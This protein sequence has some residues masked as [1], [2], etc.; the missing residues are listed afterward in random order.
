MAKRG[1]GGVSSLYVTPVGSGWTPLGRALLLTHNIYLWWSCRQSHMTDGKQPSPA[2]GLF[3]HVCTCG[4]RFSLPR[5]WDGKGLYRLQSVPK[6]PSW[7]RNLKESCLGPRD[8]C[9]QSA[10]SGAKAT[11]SSNVQTARLFCKTHPHGAAN[12]AL[13]VSPSSSKT[14]QGLQLHKGSASQP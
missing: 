13:P 9:W 12:A 6:A 5:L 2:L 10:W 1:G 7:R 4:T 3:L 11:G 8:C 14:W